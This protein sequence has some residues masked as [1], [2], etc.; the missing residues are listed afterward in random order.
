M[1]KILPKIKTASRNTLKSLMAIAP[2]LLAIIGLIGLFETFITPQMIHDLFDGNLLHDTLL[3]TLGGALSI[4]A[5]FLSYIIGGELI[6]EGIS[7]YAVTAFILSFVTLGIIQ[8]PLEFSIFGARFAII[9]NLLSLI[10]A[11][12]VSWIT[13]YT[14]VHINGYL[15]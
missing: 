5:P 2:M 7:L 3:G 1:R 9:K 6:K 4:G 12:I 15:S 11:F 8:L 10:F 14:L 13:V